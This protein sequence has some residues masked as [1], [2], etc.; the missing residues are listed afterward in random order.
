MELVTPCA[1]ASWIVVVTSV[2][3]SGSA[4]RATAARPGRLE[5]ADGGTLFLDEV[6]DISPALQQKL[7]RVLESSEFERAGEARPVRVHLRVVAATH[8]DLAALAD[9]GLFRRD[10]YFRLA[11]LPVTVP[12]L[13]E[14]ASDVPLLVEHFL[15]RLN[16]SLGRAIEGVTPEAMRRL[17]EYGWPG[18]VR[19]LEHAI[20][21]AV[22]LTRGDRIEESALPPALGA[23]GEAMSP[24][25]PHKI[26]GS[27][28]RDRILQA[29]QRTGGNRTE[30]ARLLGVSRV[31]LWKWMRAMDAHP[32]DDGGPSGGDPSD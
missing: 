15:A 21:Y 13:R 32:G 20:E 17:C 1:S 18:N 11:V 6:A 22:V 29:L 19:E 16:R 10:L 3:S 7:L 4:V 28:D 31:T 30:A 26:R 9:R 24:A 27:P 8:E 23:A 2:R 14:R 12:P 5:A 25:L